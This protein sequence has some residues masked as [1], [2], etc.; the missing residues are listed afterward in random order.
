[1]LFRSSSSTHG[2][3]G[4]DIYDPLM[5]AGETIKRKKLKDIIGPS[6]MRKDKRRDR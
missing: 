3:G 1:M 4:I 2:T 5:R 6:A